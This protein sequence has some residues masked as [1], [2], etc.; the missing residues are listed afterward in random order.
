MQGYKHLK[1]K[2]KFF[3]EYPLS[4]W[5][6]SNY[7]NYNKRGSAKKNEKTLAS[8]FIDQL[9]N[10]VRDPSIS[11][12]IE[13]AVNNIIEEVENRNKDQV[14]IGKI[15]QRPKSLTFNDI[16]FRAGQAN[17]LEL[18]AMWFLE[19]LMFSLPQIMPLSKDKLQKK[20]TR[21]NKK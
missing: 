3:S 15:Q 20:L 6:F 12:E 5:N 7:I 14:H 11:K 8:A 9:R 4:D 16:L 2:D 19:I 1:S 18:V 17:T 10:V 21:E 13:D